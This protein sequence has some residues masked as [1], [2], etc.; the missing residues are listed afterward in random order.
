MGPS[1][2]RA[3]RKAEKYVFLSGFDVVNYASYDRA[4]GV[5]FRDIDH[6]ISYKYCMFTYKISRNYKI[7]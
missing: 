5:L 4:W 7:K 6:F 1:E 3:F 2:N